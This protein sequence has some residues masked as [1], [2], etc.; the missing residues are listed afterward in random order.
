[1]Q[2]IQ[3]RRR[4]LTGLTTAGAASLIGGPTPSRAEPPPE[5]TRVRLTK[6]A[7]FA[8]RRSMLPKNC[9]TPRALP[10]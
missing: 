9:Y 3:T 7:A 2:I 8:G 6:I 10:R 1:M 5:T 4:F